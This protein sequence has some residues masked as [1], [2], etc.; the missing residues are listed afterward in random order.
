MSPSKRRRAILYRE[1][2]RMTGAIQPSLETRLNHPIG[3]RTSNRQ[4]RQYCSA[5][6]LI[7]GPYKVKVG[8]ASY[9]T[10]TPTLS[11][12]DVVKT[13]TTEYVNRMKRNLA[14]RKAW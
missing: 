8:N 11:S 7:V 10:V 13:S 12:I 9:R 1:A 4:E 2:Q 3:D 5:P 14:G 6:F